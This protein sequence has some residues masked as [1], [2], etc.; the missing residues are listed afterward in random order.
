M[1]TYKDTILTLLEVIDKLE[2]A[3]R[4]LWSVNR[5]MLTLYSQTHDLTDEEIDQ[6][7][8]ETLMEETKK[9]NAP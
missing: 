2:E 5:K 4:L 8:A 7:K 9:K 6:Y 3:N 1:G